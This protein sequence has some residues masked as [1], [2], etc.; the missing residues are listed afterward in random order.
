MYCD[1][2]WSA[3]LLVRMLFS[4]DEERFNLEKLDLVWSIIFRKIF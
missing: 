2:S 3:S 1:I 4:E